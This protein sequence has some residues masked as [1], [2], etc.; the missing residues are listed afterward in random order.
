MMNTF[1]I[2]YGKLSISA[3][4]TLKAV[5]DGDPY[6]GI[7][8]GFARAGRTNSLGALLKRGMI[9]INRDSP[10]YRVTKH[11]HYVMTMSR[12]VPLPITNK[13]TSA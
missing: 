9:S 11:G 12:Q 10:V 2:R 7:S 6:A 1:A 5:A 13:E 8:S 4:A 3:S